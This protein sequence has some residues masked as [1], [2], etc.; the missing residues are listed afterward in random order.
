MEA[1]RQAGRTV[2]VVVR[3]G[4]GTRVERETQ[5]YDDGEERWV[6]SRC[7]RERGEGLDTIEGQDEKEGEKRAR[8][9]FP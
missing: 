6:R 5:A 1:Q 7:G 2:D 3:E 9:A 4:A 8:I